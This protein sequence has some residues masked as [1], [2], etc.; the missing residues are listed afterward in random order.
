MVKSYN[1]TYSI[2]GKVRRMDVDAKD[3][4]YAIG[5]IASTR[6]VKVSEVKVIDYDVYRIKED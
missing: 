1:I 4:D 6:G 3:L 2:E 5:V